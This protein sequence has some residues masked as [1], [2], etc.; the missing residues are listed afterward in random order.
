MRIVMLLLV[1]SREDVPVLFKSS[2]FGTQ[3]H[4]HN[5]HNSFQLN[6]YGEALLPACVYRDLHGSKFHY[7]WAHSTRAQN[8]VLVNGQGQTPHTA[9]PHGRIARH[10]LGEQWDYVVGDA[11]AAYAGHLTRALRHVVFVKPDLI[12]LY[13]EL[14]AKEPS[15]FEFLLH[16]LK[17]F[18]LDT[19]RAELRLELPRAGLTARYLSAT[20]LQFRQWNGFEPPPT[21]EFPNMWHVEAGTVEKRRAIGMLT[22]L[23]P[24]RAGQGSAFTADRIETDTALGVA[25]RHGSRQVTVSFPKG[26]AEIEPSVSP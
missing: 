14:E 15:T 3:S 6:A 19:E 9:A 2:P 16:G 18:T 7:Q 11:T 4:G 23:V 20:P 17:P 8:A 13:D 10:T 1:D 5:A 26:G 21:R 25:I 24:H 12:V 22:L